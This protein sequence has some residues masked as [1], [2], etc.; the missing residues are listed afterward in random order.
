MKR[1]NTYFDVRYFVKFL[2]LFGGLYALNT[3]MI[4]ITTPGGMYSRFIEQHLN[5]PVWLRDL[6]ILGSRGLTRLAGYQTEIETT[7]INGDSIT[8]VTGQKVIIGW[9]CYGVGIMSFWFAFIMAHITRKNILNTLSWTFAGLIAIWFVNCMRIGLLL[10]SLAKG[11][12]LNE[13]I[14]NHDMFTYGSYVVI[15]LM[16]LLYFNRKKNKIERLASTKQ[17]SIS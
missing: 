3:F 11:W 17:F 14:D 2:F 4:G 5:Y 6:V 1:L 16:I 7:Y 8:L 10:I 13:T 15:I 12:R 9:V